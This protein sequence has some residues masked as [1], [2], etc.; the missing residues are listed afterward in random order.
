MQ[1][2]RVLSESECYLRCHGDRTGTVDLLGTV[3][4]HRPPP[5]DWS[6]LE[7]PEQPLVEDPAESEEEG[8]AEAA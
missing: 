2:L 4:S 8:A 7:P 3:R 6:L 1:W 5:P